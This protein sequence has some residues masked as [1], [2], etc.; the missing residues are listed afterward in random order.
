MPALTS[1]H[2]TNGPT[3]PTR[4]THLT[5]RRGALALA[6]VLSAVLLT[7]S[8]QL[9]RWARAVGP[10]ITGRGQ[11]STA[12]GPPRGPTSPGRPR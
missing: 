11:H 7:Q 10:A 1:R 8:G 12:T 4:P 6:A 5:R 3:R 2:G 9:G